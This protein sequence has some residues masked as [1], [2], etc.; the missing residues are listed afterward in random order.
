M[1]RSLL[2]IVSLAACYVTLDQLEFFNGLRAQSNQAQRPNRQD[3]ALAATIRRLTNRSTA[4]LAET[5]RPGGG[6]TLT[7][8]QR[9]QNLPLAKVDASGEVAVGCID[10]LAEANHFF[11]RNLE[12]GEQYPTLG[13]TPSKGADQATRLGMSEA[14]YQFYQKLIADAEQRRALSPT[15]ATINILTNDAPGE[16]FN[17][18]TAKAPEGGNNGTTL[19]QQRLILF[20][21]AAS[22][23][24]DFLD[25]NVPTNVLAQFDPLTP[26]DSGGGVL[27]SAGAYYIDR[28]FPGAPFSNTW[29]HGA[30]AN[31]L[32]GSA[33]TTEYPEIV[34]TFNS[35]VDTG[36]MNRPFYYGLNNSTPS[37]TINLLV[38]LLHELGHGLGFS[39]FVNGSNGQFINGFPDIYARFMFDQ[40][41]GLYW[42]QMNNA[43]REASA[44]NEDNVFW[45]GPN[46]LIASG[47][48]TT[49]RDAATGRVELYTP[50]SLQP[51]SSISHWSTAA[52]PNLLME[53]AIN[54]GLPIDLDLTRQQMRDIGWYRDSTADLVPDT[55]T[56]VQPSGGTYTI[57]SSANITWTNTGGFNRNVM[58]EL[59][60]DGG[61]TFPVV[62]AS[63]V[64]NTGSYTFTVPNY[65]TSQGRIRVREYNFVAPAGVSAANFT[66]TNST[67][68]FNDVPVS[69]PFFN[70]IEKMAARGITL[71]CGNGNYCPDAN[72]TREQMAIFIERTLGVF[73]PPVPSGQTFQDVSLSLLGYAFIE[74]FV[75]RGITQGC[76]A[77]PP[78]LYCPTASVTREQMAIFIERAL[79]V[80]TPPAGPATPTFADVPNS[81]ATD[82]SYEFIEDFVARGITSGCATGPRR[83]CPTAPVT[84]GQMAV[85]LV[86]AFNL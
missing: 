13:R 42:H 3:L 47:F 81:G 14:E 44:V 70:E 68:R 48:L 27:G 50:G 15:L 25:S 4:G 49:G 63:N 5:Y 20:N 62:I 82:Y 75:T 6:V 37:G 85:F 30:L 21:Y 55:I 41:Q 1:K 28:D 46:V 71:G 57:G 79:G 11:G 8:G 10:S 54:L 34:T 66:L 39:S 24:S 84:R 51:G 18:P 69:H 23:W 53:P 17:D 74:D 40:T 33:A 12:T 19:G 77:G 29:Y 86:R 80:F 56:N 61:A 31:K 60:T 65:P 73:T 7:L 2:I 32:S 22:I 35:S 36:C 64:N 58:I 59:S 45:D 26:C 76:A 43:Q 16:G 67:Q 83:Y 52:S 72:V 38:V 78:R 9:F